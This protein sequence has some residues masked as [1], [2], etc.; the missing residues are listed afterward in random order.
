MKSN[1]NNRLP[2]I[3]LFIS[4]VTLGLC[5]GGDARATTRDAAALLAEIEKAD[6]SAKRIDLAA[7][8]AAMTPTPVAALKA[9]LVRK[10]STDQAG[11]R[12][13]L[14]ASG[15]EVPDATGRFTIPKRQTKKEKER[16]DRFDWLP[17]IAGQPAQAGLGET[18][19]DV[20]AIR[21]LAAS[22]N[23]DAGIVIFDFAF[24]EQGLIYRDECGRYLRK[25]SP[26]S[27]PALIHGSQNRK[28]R[29]ISRYAN[30]QLERLD[31]QNAHKAIASAPTE[32]LKIAI[33]TAFADS[34]YREA[35]F[36]VL[37]NVNHVA[38]RVRHAARAAW[39][40]YVSGRPPPKPPERKLSLPNGKQT[41]EREP[42][43]LDHRRLGDT[44][45]RVR[46]TEVTGET[47][48]TN[49]S[50]AALTEKLFS[51]YDERRTRALTTDFDAA[52]ALESAGKHDQATA[53]FDRILA[54]APGFEKRAKMLPAYLS[55]AKAL[56]GEKKW[57][58]AAIAYGKA[59]SIAP[60]DG[61][62]KKA[63]QK[64][65]LARANAATAAGQ[66]N[67][68]E[69]AVADAVMVEAESGPSKKLILFGGLAALAAS[70]I[71]LLLG[72]AA[73]REST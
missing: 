23:P 53:I 28:D 21:A 1:C 48:P 38:P 30:Y 2:V 73:R 16:R 5:L 25:M 27:L 8:L 72:L 15:A 62:A 47:P 9:H 44:A 61:D 66:D 12:A 22:T 58:E 45:I 60:Q 64:H 20:A 70:L 57:S 68:A 13:L 6:N 56:E 29:S 4:C 51:V 3:A 24:S 52:L 31:R 40:E 11:R 26:Y 69:L 39:T 65:H 34:Q 33:I 42:L 10:R 18:L 17:A 46:L 67:S 71:L 14:I 59:S 63:L 54:Q 35:V 37:D 43:W 7:E 36:A 32:N 19:S 55:Q 41:K 50:L 49:A